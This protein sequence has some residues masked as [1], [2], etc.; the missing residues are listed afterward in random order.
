MKSLHQLKLL[1]C[2][3]IHCYNTIGFH[4]SNILSSIII[5]ST[6]GSTNETGS[7]RYCVVLRGNDFHV[8]KNIFQASDVTVVKCLLLRVW[9]SHGL[10]R[11]P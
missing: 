7:I 6:I 1:N 4:F 5:L 10:R 9:W 11:R 3:E 8:L 2:K